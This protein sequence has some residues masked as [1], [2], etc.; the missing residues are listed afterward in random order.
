MNGV[1][2]PP[3]PPPPPHPASSAGHGGGTSGE[4]SKSTS[5]SSRITL[6]CDKDSPLDFPAVTLAINPEKI[7][8]AK[9]SSAQGAAN[10]VTSDFQNSVKASGNLTMTLSGIRLIG[11]PYTAATIHTLVALA[12]PWPKNSK[13]TQTGGRSPGLIAIQVPPSGMSSLGTAAAGGGASA[14]GASSGGAPAGGAPT[15]G[16][17]S[18][19][20]A[21]SSQALSLPKVVFSWGNGLTYPVTVVGV[22]VDITR[23]SPTGELISATVTSL[24]MKMMPK[25][26]SGT[27]PT[28]G[29]RAGRGTHVIVAGDSLVRIAVRNYG[30]PSAWRAIAAVNS[31]DDPLRLAVGRQLYLPGPDEIEELDLAG[32]RGEV[33]AS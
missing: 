2:L 9:K 5:A 15:G 16:A 13:L 8:L 27:N 24:N 11:S 17:S 32:R 4:A 1:G 10:L 20:T 19:K 23:V 18:G 7:K 14:G 3:P 12:T 29:G 33:I 30:D 22:D 28:S 25:Q 21:Q 26:L 31:L 6:T